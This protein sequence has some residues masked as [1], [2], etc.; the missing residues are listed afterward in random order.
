MQEN[1]KKTKKKTVKRKEVK[2]KRV[3][4][5]TEM[6]S[7]MNSALK[8]VGIGALVLFAV[9][10]AVFLFMYKSGEIFFRAFA[11]LRHNIKFG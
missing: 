7:T 10:I 9:A 3:K 11:F 8:S 1:N 5:K 2:R 4:E 6:K